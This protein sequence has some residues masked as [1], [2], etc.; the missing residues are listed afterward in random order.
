MTTTTATSSTSTSASLMSALGAGSGIDV[1]SLAK[2]LVEAERAPR[3][4]VIDGRIS[5]A[6][7]QISGYGAMKYSLST[8]QTAFEGLND[9]SDLASLTVSNS[10]PTAFTMTTTSAATARAYSLQVTQIAK[11][12]TRAASF[13]ASTEFNAGSEFWINLSL[14]GVALDPIAVTTDSPAGI[15][16]AINGA[17]LGI[18][19]QLI[20]TG[21]DSGS[22]VSIVLT[23]PEGEDNT[24]SVSASRDEAG[25]STIAE[26]SDSDVWGQKQAAS[27]AQIVLDGLT[28][29]RDSNEIDD[30]ITGATISLYS[31]TSGTAR[32]ALQRD[33]STIQTKMEALVTAYN[34]LQDSFD[35][36]N[37]PDSEVE[38]YGGALAYD[39]LL[40]TIRNQ[41]RSIF[42]SE[43]STP[44]TTI[45]YAW[46]VGLSLQSDGHLEL[47]TDTLESALQDN[48]DDAVMMLTAG[49]S[50]NSVYG[51]VDSGLAGD[52][53]KT[54]Y[55]MLSST[56]VVESQIDTT[57]TSLDGYKE[58]LAALETRME[59]LQERYLQQF[60]AMDDIV[61]QANST[62]DNLAAKLF[63]SDN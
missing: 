10:Q 18:T 46:Q 19:A 60:S 62:R 8:L 12:E 1:E 11:G 31:T 52:A 9:A 59:Q 54:I 34:D 4:E 22:D 13:S 35:V 14:A 29:D 48:F 27:N 20:Q 6:E 5:K 25:T 24:I 30:V 44:G 55:K 37:N 36:L 49:R 58:Q 43:S 61:S 26:L 2:S 32:L 40:R 47:D 15:V 23:G 45:K 41:L 7:G 28:I 63:S 50:T 51:S 21:S 3:K 53:V 57:G 56:G 38:T 17:D 16:R 39:S 33:T 42:T